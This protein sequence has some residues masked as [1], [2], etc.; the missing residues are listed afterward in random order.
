MVLT[1]QEEENIKM[2]IKV[3]IFQENENSRIFIK[4]LT[5]KKRE[6]RLYPQDFFRARN[7]FMKAVMIRYKLSSASPDKVTKYKVNA[8]VNE[9]F[10]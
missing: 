6:Y 7:N 2:F 9:M 10:F 5:L 8:E 1:F 3:S 4:V